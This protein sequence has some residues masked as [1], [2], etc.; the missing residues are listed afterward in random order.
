MNCIREKKQKLLSLFQQGH[1][2]VLQ[3][4]KSDKAIELHKLLMRRLVYCTS[5]SKNMV[6][7]AW[8]CLPFGKNTWKWCGCYSISSTVTEI[9]N[10]LAFASS[11]IQCNATL[12]QRIWLPKWPCL[13]KSLLNGY[14]DAARGCPI[15][16]SRVHLEEPTLFHHRLPSHHS[17]LSHWTW[18]WS[19]LNRDSKP[20]EE[21]KAS[22]QKGR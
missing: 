9:L 17:N 7:N 1:S 5:S 2:S 11:R 22:V 14:E 3:Q 18:H 12:W 10:K 16:T 19:R 8:L 13:G 6:V 15:S 4:Q 21:L 20:K